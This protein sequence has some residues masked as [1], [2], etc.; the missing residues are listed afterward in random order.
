MELGTVD[1]FSN[2]KRYGYIATSKKGEKIYFRLN[3]G[4]KIEAGSN[5]P[6]F[7]DFKLGKNP[8]EGDYIVFKRSRNLEGPKASPWGFERDFRKAEQKIYT[9]D[10]KVMLQATHRR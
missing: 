4:M 5:E 1:F 9:H 2:E 6:Q 8:E 10:L 3:D 7:S